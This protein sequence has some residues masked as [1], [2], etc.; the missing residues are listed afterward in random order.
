M[1]SVIPRLCP[2]T[3]SLSFSL[4]FPFSFSF[5]L[6]PPFTFILSC[7]FLFPLSVAHSLYTPILPLDTHISSLLLLLFLSIVPS[8]SPLSRLLF[9]L[10]SSHAVFS[11]MPSSVS[12]K[13]SFLF[14]HLSLLFPLFTSFSLSLCFVSHIPLI[15]RFAFHLRSRSCFRFRRFRALLSSSLSPSSPPLSPLPVHFPLYLVSLAFCL[16]VLFPLLAPLNY[17][18]LARFISRREFLFPPPLFLFLRLELSLISSL[19]LLLPSS[20]SLARSRGILRARCILFLS[21]SLY[22]VPFSFPLFLS[23]ARE[24]GG[25]ELF[26]LY[27]KGGA[28]PT[29]L[30]WMGSRMTLILKYY[31]APLSLA[32]PPRPRPSRA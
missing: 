8:P 17:D 18:R 15:L 6:L 24:R 27:G 29:G 9:V 22:L 23:R 13:T 12:R 25:Q 14:V 5:A 11:C 21:L 1:P 16:S 28:E 2:P 20:S 31:L 19:S 10:S 32:S 30:L 4:S 3:L 7:A 26:I